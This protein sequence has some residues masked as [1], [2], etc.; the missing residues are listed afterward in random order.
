MFASNTTSPRNFH[1][2]SEVDDLII[3]DLE[4]VSKWESC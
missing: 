2:E 4:S 3:K 1:G